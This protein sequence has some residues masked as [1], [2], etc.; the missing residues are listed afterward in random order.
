VRFALGQL[1]AQNRHHEFEHLARDLARATVTRR[2]LPATGPVA[3]GGDQGRDFETFS[4]ELPGQVLRLGRELGIG[5]A[6]DVGFC[7]TLQQDGL[8]NKI[9][10]DVAT[11]VASGPAVSLVIAYCEANMTTAARHR[12]QERV[13]TRHGVRLEVFDGTAIAELLAQRHTFWIAAEHLHLPARTL[14]S[15]VPEWYEADL[16]RWREQTEPACTFG[17]LIDLATCLRHA[18][19]NED[20]A[21]DLPFWL[22]QLQPL[23]KD[24]VPAP[25]RR[26]ARHHIVIA[27]A[28][29]VGDLR[30]VDDAVAALLDDAAL[31]SDYTEL[32][33]AA[34]VLLFVI[35][36]H[37]AGTTAH[38][39]EQ[40][41]RW[42][43]ALTERVVEL[44]AAGP[45]PNP[46]CTLLATLAFLKLQP[47]LDALGATG[48]RYE[49][50][51]SAT[52]LSHRELRRL[53][54]SGEMA[55]RQLPALDCDGALAA[56]V[57]LVGEL[58]GAPLFPVDLLAEL[59]VL[60]AELLVEDPRYD[61][62][63]AAID[64]RGAAVDG[65][66]TTADH[67]RDRAMTLLRTGRL[68][69]ALRDMHRARMGWLSGEAARAL[70]L[71]TLMTADIF[72]RLRLYAAAKY[73][74]LVAASLVQEA[75]LDLYPRALF[76]AA[77]ADYHQGAWLSA[78]EANRT[79][80]T[81]HHLFAEQPLDLDEHSGFRNALVEF[82]LLDSAAHH[83]GPIFVEY[84]ATRSRAVGVDELLQQMLDVK[85]ITPWWAGLT[86]EELTDACIR[87]LG[88]PPF[89]DAGTR[90]AI[91]W[92]A[93]GVRWSVEFDNDAGDS[94]VGQRLA[95]A[96]QIVLADL[97][98]RDP[99][100]LPTTVTIDVASI[101]PDAEPVA[102]P[103]IRGNRAEWRVRLP[104]AGPPSPDD[105][106]RIHVQTF[107]AVEA[108]VRDVSVRS[109]SDLEQI[110]SAAITSGLPDNIMFAMPIDVVLPAPPTDAP[111]S[112][113]PIDDAFPE[114]HPL[115][116]LPTTPGPGFS[117]DTAAEQAAQR[118]EDIP[119]LLA[120][121]LPTLRADPAFRLT[122]AQLRQA[123]W[124]DWH[125][126]V[127]VH[128]VTVNERLDPELVSHATERVDALR[129]EFRRPEHPEAPVP[130]GAF[131][132]DRLT[133]AL[134]V[135]LTSTLMNHWNLAVRQQ[136]IDVVAVR[137]LLDARFG[138]GSSDAPHE[139]PFA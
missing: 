126:L 76:A 22:D 24:D 67:A 61:E 38:G 49:V 19:E 63:V 58:D 137:T 78:A 9:S 111:R 1:S 64:R 105:Y 88:R 73:Y 45:R 69:E 53:I 23:L 4:S 41:M 17:Q 117:P 109:D 135:S 60:Y 100:L 62:I 90:R 6:D 108:I 77:A 40:L 43:A 85:P 20:A 72:G 10:S 127:A 92:S 70:V 130:V 18:L 120:A 25:I 136:P 107:L 84:V 89:S 71:A 83:Q 128:N 56:L 59:L 113:T 116:A 103:G 104:A 3:G 75:D 21:V 51:R 46:T 47:D 138:Y 37:G 39:V 115:L 124:R 11:I 102:I 134:D 94:A 133:T 55:P 118:Y 119:L 48:I 98:R 99:V 122:V 106:H 95:A 82:L 125:L 132:A 31:T 30:P 114:P 36:A 86:A 14:P 66:A 96:L 15:E 8:P 33:D 57:R 5:D 68:L 97:A 34:V 44:L 35:V 129:E 29:G 12:L 101:D 112:G 121:T 52:T 13:R 139:D 110:F 93:L 2:L 26:R 54:L 32:D 87:E 42:N 79:A 16:A 80:V 123:G 7:C 65:A 131:T 74:A 50:D 28:R 27:H 81:S 91:R